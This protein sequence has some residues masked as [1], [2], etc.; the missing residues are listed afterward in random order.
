MDF[1]R[2]LANMIKDIMGC[3]QR[4]ANSGNGDIFLFS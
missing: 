4:A 2:L 1:T 3:S